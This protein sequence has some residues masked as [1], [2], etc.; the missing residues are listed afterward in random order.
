[1]LTFNQLCGIIW[2]QEVINMAKIGENIR[3]KREELGL[4]QEELATRM[5]YK[6]KSTINKIELGIN[7]IPQNKIAKFAEVLGTTPAVLM[8]WVDEQTEKKNDVLA[9]IVLQLRKDAELLEM[10][11]KLSRLN[12]ENRQALKPVLNAFEVSEK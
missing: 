11:E 2:L 1:M 8:G 5:G 12:H 3:R 7:D 4:S 6:S 10:V 9:N